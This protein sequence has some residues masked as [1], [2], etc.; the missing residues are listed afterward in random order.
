MLAIINK[1]IGDGAVGLWMNIKIATRKKG[2]LCY[3]SYNMSCS[4]PSTTT[5]N[6]W[7]TS[8]A[9]VCCHLCAKSVAFSK[10]EQL[11]Y[12]LTI[13]RDKYLGVFFVQLKVILISKDK[14]THMRAYALF[15]VHFGSLGIFMQNRC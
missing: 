3:K 11:I 14:N 5:P 4:G 1:V 7:S 13:G 12:V 8:W 10:Y 15:S 2:R 6:N 9:A